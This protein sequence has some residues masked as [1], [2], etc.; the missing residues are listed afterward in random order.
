MYFWGIFGIK[1]TINFSCSAME[2]TKIILPEKNFGKAKVSLPLPYLLSLEK[3]SWQWFWEKGLKELFQEVS[4]IRDY[5][6]KELELWFLDYKLDELKYKTDLEARLNNDSY[7]VALRVKTRLVNLK[8][9]EIKEQEIFLTDFPVM[10]ERGTFIVNGVERVAIAQLIRSPGVFIT[11]QPIAGKNYFGAKIIPNRGAWLELETES[12]GF[13]GIKIDRKR[14][15]AATTILRAFGIEDD[16]KIK[17]LFKDVDKGSVNYINETL[18]RDITHNQAEALVE[19]YSRLRPGDMVTPDTA[20][21]LIWNMFFNFERYDLSKVG[22]WRTWQRLP[23]LKTRKAK[24]KQKLTDE[25][26]IQDRVLKPED[27]V[28]TIREIIR[29]NNDP[30][31]KP[32]QIDHLGN[33]RVRTLAEL[34]INRMRVGIMRMERIIKDR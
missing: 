25:I 9:K 7:E 6:G 1:L 11:A 29:L 3:E 2:E 28:E 18:K 26:T 4:P 16:A 34:L 33:R 12:S 24:K 31:G 21:E 17:E 32:D 5:T 8:S 10:T 14:K 22:R 27:V 23:E 15:V 13:L 19:I 30:E 20:R